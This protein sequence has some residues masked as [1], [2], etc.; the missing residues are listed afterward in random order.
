MQLRAMAIARWVL[1]VPVPPIST[2]LRCWAM[3]PPAA[4]SWTSVALI[5]VPEKSKA[6]RSLASG[7]LAMGRAGQDVE[8][9]VGGVDAVG[10]RLGTGGLDRRQP[11]GEHR[12][13]DVDHLPIAV[14]GA[15]ELAPHAL[16]RGR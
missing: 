14:V 5:G 4:R 3:K 7:S 16:H 10:A 15:G 2:A 6:A 13:E 11:V 8:K 9:D 1:P 12:G